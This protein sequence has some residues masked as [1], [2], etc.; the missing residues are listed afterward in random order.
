MR[1]INARTNRNGDSRND[2]RRWHPVPIHHGKAPE[3]IYARSLWPIDENF[4]KPWDCTI[5]GNW[6]HRHIP[7]KLF[8]P[9]GESEPM[10]RQKWGDA[11]ERA[12]RI[13]W[14]HPNL[15]PPRMSVFFRPSRPVTPWEP[16][17]SLGEGMLRPYI[18]E[19]HPVWIQIA[20]VNIYGDA[21]PF[22]MHM[23]RW[24]NGKRVDVWSNSPAM[25]KRDSGV[26]WRIEPSEIG[27]ELRPHG[28]PIE[29]DPI[30][31]ESKSPLH[32]G[33]EDPGMEDVL[34]FYQSKASGKGVKKGLSCAVDREHDFCMC[35]RHHRN[36]VIWHVALREPSHAKILNSQYSTCLV[37]AQDGMFYEEKRRPSGSP[38]YKDFPA[39]IT[40]AW[41]TDRPSDWLSR[42]Y[43]RERTKW[44]DFMASTGWKLFLRQ[45]TE[46]GVDDRSGWRNREGIVRMHSCNISLNPADHTS[47]KDAEAGWPPQ[48]SGSC[49]D[50][51]LL[52]GSRCRPGDYANAVPDRERLAFWR[53]S[54]GINRGPG[55]HKEISRGGVRPVFG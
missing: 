49:R 7:R 19:P 12:N 29:G 33:G 24:E 15:M 46:D 38:Y 9:L 43:K 21:E 4:F 52:L 16:M 3:K 17:R 20:G 39:H 27:G 35:P 6:Y 41:I 30:Y 26:S 22:E 45:L 55:C 28:F 54:P 1:L 5:D 14:L 10:P 42:M 44:A 23:Q 48:R 53:Y 11:V 47:K 36:G 34:G 32:F 31:D 2:D 40:I 51:L 25:Y 37:P 8:S 13:C 50:Y 18:A